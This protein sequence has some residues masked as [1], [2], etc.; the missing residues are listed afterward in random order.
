ML[1]NMI[2][3]ILSMFLLHEVSSKILI[4]GT[5]LTRVEPWQSLELE[6]QI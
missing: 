1:V 6:F 5:R 2:I 4:L 3:A